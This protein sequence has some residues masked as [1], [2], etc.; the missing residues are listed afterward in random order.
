MASPAP[1]AGRV[2]EAD[3]A[4]VLGLIASAPSRRES[5]GA[6]DV[7]GRFDFWFDGGACRYDTGV[8]YFELKDGTRCFSSVSRRLSL[9]IRFPD[10]DE[11][12]IL[13]REPDERAK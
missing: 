12:S 3:V 7:L 5:P 4:R 11:V 6:G 1:I 9:T 13:Q 10:G 2:R 8:T